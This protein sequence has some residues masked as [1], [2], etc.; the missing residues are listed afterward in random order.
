MG[1]P[2]SDDVEMTD[3][4]E[5]TVLDRLPQGLWRLRTGRGECLASLHETARLSGLCPIPGQR[6]AIR[7][8]SFDPSRAQ[9]V[10]LCADPG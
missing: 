3:T 2:L 1:W 6:V 5:A 8:T 7:L 10:A 9:I 4:I